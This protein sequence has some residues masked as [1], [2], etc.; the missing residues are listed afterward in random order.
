MKLKFFL[1]ISKSL[2]LRVSGMGGYTSKCEK[3]QNHCTLV[4]M[5]RLTCRTPSVW[6]YCSCTVPANSLAWQAYLPAYGRRYFS[7]PKYQSGI[8]GSY[9]EK[10]AETQTS[11]RLASSLVR[12]PTSWMIS[13][14]WLQ[15]PF[16][17]H[18]SAL[19][20]GG[21]TLWV[22]HFHTTHITGFK[23]ILLAL[24]C[25]S[26]AAGN[27]AGTIGSAMLI[28]WIDICNRRC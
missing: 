17:D 16:V 10:P 28:N 21:K 25:Q 15:I 12:A 18:L 20:E 3:S 14:T 19:T 5:S 22:R 6:L 27:T 13:R 26:I 23:C 1:P 9:E 8:E 7:K 2:G 4:I 24:K 11:T